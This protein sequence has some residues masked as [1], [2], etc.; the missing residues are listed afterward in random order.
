[1]PLLVAVLSAKKGSIIIIENPE[2][3]LHPN[4]ISR[5]TELFCIAAQAG[6][7]IIIETHSDHI[8]NGVAVQCVIHEQNQ[9]KGIDKN[10][11]KIYQFYRDQKENFTTSQLIPI[12]EGGRLTSNPNG[13]FDQIQLD[14][15]K[16]LGF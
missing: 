5:L 10:L 15:E 8:I 11:L 2:A 6:I 3:H 7:Q 1:M 4:G 9:Q 16:I 14:L 13:F 12:E